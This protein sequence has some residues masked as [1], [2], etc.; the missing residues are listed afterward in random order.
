MAQNPG[1]T[2]EVPETK[3]VAPIF[4]KVTNTPPAKPAVEAARE[5]PYGGYQISTNLAALPLKKRLFVTNNFLP[6][7]NQ[8]LKQFPTQHHP[9]GA[10][11]IEAVSVNYGVNGFV[12]VLANIKSDDGPFQIITETKGG[13]NHLMCFRDLTD[14]DI[15]VPGTLDQLK[16][17]PVGSQ[18]SAVTT[19]A[20]AKAFVMNILKKYDFDFHAY[21][22]PPV[23]VPYTALPNFG[24]W[25]VHY[26]SKWAGTDQSYIDF[27]VDGTGQKGPFFRWVY[28]VPDTWSLPSTLEN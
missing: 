28:Q 7:A 25:Q 19:A 9:F 26:V 16:K 11:D 12:S 13:R 27:V 14:F 20:D 18:T 10:N 21:L 17:L 5:D 15:S 8:F 1:A 2:H 23:V 6:T 4:D 24:L 22:D 3:Q